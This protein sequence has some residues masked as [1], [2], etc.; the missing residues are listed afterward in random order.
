[1]DRL[2]PEERSTL[3]SKV[4]SKDTAPELE[5]RRA[6]W[7]EGFRYRLHDNRLPGR[8][9]LV[10][11][12]LKTVIFVHGCLW[13]G[14]QCRRGATPKSNVD[15]WR[16]K[17]VS[18]RQR[19]MIAARNLRALGWSVLTVWTCQLRSKARS[20]RTMKRVLAALRNRVHQ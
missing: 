4:R 16:N 1:M 3:M 20:E 6:I 12:K 17:V 7:C 13:H 5:V 10:F 11:P 15:Y 8:P 18:N 9:D 2:A 19:D 14:H